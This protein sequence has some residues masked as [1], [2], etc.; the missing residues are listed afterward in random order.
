MPV[1]S[2]S[3]TKCSCNF[4]YLWFFPSVTICILARPPRLE[5][6]SPFFNHVIFWPFRDVTHSNKQ[7][8][9]TFAVWLL[10]SVSN[11]NGCS[12]QNQAKLLLQYTENELQQLLALNA[13]IA[14]KVQYKF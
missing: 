5:I 1:L 2:C 3:I 12:K 8:P 9:L 14:Q 10:S 13:K 7:R 11:L 4:T 6:T